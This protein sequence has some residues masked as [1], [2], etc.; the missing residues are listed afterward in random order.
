MEEVADDHDVGVAGHGV[1]RVVV[2]DSAAVQQRGV[3]DAVCGGLHHLRVAEH[4]GVL[5]VDDFLAEQAIRDRRVPGHL[6]GRQIAV[7]FGVRGDGG[8][9]VEDDVRLRPGPV[10][11]HVVDAGPLLVC[12]RDPEGIAGIEH[13]GDEI[14]VQSLLLD[15]DRRIAWLLIQGNVVCVARIDDGLHLLFGHSGRS[16]DLDCVRPAGADVLEGNSIREVLVRIDLEDVVPV[17]PGPTH[18]KSVRGIALKPFGCRC[19]LFRVV[20]AQPGI[21]SSRPSGSASGN[22]CRGR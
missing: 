4:P 3:V 11:V 6:P 22:S 15:D 10:P 9:G 18:T 16:A 2:V 20:N 17:V 12:A 1:R 14:P 5:D 8:L 21:P 19:D 13:R 7:G